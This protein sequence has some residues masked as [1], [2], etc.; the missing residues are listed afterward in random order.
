M[1]IK[2]KDLDILEIKECGVKIAIMKGV[3]E[4][5]EDSMMLCKAVK[6]L[7][8]SFLEIGVGSGL[9]VVANAKAQ[10]G[11]NEIVGVDVEKKAIE[12]A[13]LNAKLNGVKVKLFLSDLFENVKKRYDYIAFNP[14]YLEKGEERYDR[15]IHDNGEIKRFVE[16]VPDYVE[17]AFFLILSDNNSRFK[18]YWK[19][20]KEME[21][22]GFEIKIKEKKKMFFERLYLVEGKRRER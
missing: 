9:S 1:K 22:K 15:A 10:K 14:P 6:E 4:I 12:N 2:A 18:E 13:K 5:R 8:G 11:K 19:K 21:E 17:K 20:L 3:Y 16:E 7:K